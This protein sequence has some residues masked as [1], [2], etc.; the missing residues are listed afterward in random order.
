MSMSQKISIPVDDAAANHLKNLNIP[1]ISLP[2]QEGNY[3]RLDRS[4]TF[5]MII[6]FFPMT[7]RPDMP[8]PDNW[9]KIPGANGCTL[10]TCKFRDNYD[11]FISLNA[12]PIGISTQTVDYNKEMTTRLRVPFDVLSDEKLEL[13]NALGLPTFLVKD[14][15]YLKRLTLIIEKK[16]VKKVFYPI[17]PIDKHIDD[18]LKWLKEN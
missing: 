3:L 6:Y 15:T 4:D 5:R 8:L 2:N 18:V 7:G 9:N 14:K 12:V 13:K 16:M 11:N 10:Q 1:S 17:Y